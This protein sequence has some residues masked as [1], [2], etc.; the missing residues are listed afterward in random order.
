MRRG[1]MLGVRLRPSLLSE[2][3][4]MVR[5]KQGVEDGPKSQSHMSNV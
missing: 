5:E 3:G 1:R 4:Q 2:C